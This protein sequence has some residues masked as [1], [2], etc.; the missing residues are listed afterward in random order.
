MTSDRAVALNRAAAADSTGELGL[1]IAAEGRETIAPLMMQVIAQG[2]KHGE[3]A[4]DD[5]SSACE[6]WLGLLIGDW[7]IR[8]VIGRM[9]QPDPATIARRAG[10]AL[11]HFLVLYRFG[12]SAS[13]NA[14]DE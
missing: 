14:Q 12:P 13:Q 6:T 8:R 7:Q 9:P 2:G 3:L 1:T 11:R 10:D 5:L 4:F